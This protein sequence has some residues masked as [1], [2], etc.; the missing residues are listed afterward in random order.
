MAA[1][2]IQPASNLSAIASNH[3]EALRIVVV[4]KNSCERD[5]SSAI[6]VDQLP[7]LVRCVVKSHIERF[8]TEIDFAIRDAKLK[9]KMQVSFAPP[10]F[11]Y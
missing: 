4:R 7:P 5:V 1:L 11:T 8:L 6:P 2:H 9:P 10:E 3:Y